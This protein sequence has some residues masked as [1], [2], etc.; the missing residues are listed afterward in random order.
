MTSTTRKRLTLVPPAPRCIKV[1]YPTKREAQDAARKLHDR[2]L[3]AYRCRNC[4]Q[5]H[6]GHG[7]AG[8]RSRY[9]FAHDRAYIGRACNDRLEAVFAELGL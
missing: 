9:K 3:Q 5:Y 1:A 4:D 6:I 8:R 7:E 2:K